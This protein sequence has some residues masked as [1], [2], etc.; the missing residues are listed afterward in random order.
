V[1]AVEPEIVEQYVRSGK[2]RLVFRD[3]LN[4]GERSE[5]ASEAAACAGEQGYFWEMHA[6][7]FQNQDEIWRTNAAGLVD[8][9]LEFAAKVENLDLEDFNQCMASR[10]TLDKLKEADK[11]QRNRG[12]T[13]QPVFEIGEQRLVGLQSFERMSEV[14]ETTL[15]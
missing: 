13:S 3:V 11:E 4:H 5:R 6:L 12:I 2:V 14:I 10:R 1:L 15:K 9:M 8:L 7:L